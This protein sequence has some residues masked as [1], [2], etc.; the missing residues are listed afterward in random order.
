MAE[1]GVLFQLH[2]K[3][4]CELCKQG[5]PSATTVRRSALDFCTRI[6][7]VPRAEFSF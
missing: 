1:V 3:H 5:L 2:D 4:M 7:E 6:V